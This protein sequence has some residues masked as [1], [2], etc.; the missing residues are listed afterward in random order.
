MNWMM[1]ARREI[2]GDG[3]KPTAIAAEGNATAVT[4]VAAGGQ[5]T[6]QPS[7]GSNGS[8]SS[9]LLRGSSTDGEEYEERAAIMQYDGGL[10]RAE[11]ERV[12]WHSVYGDQRLH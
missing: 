6:V 4:A 11:A 8:G 1:R 12:A 9:L 2:A 10:S 7:N 5:N 3:R